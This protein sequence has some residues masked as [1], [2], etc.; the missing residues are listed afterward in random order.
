LLAVLVM[1]AGVSA[2][3]SPGQLL[4]SL[5]SGLASLE[6]TQ[7]SQV[8]T[9]Q[10]KYWARDWNGNIWLWLSCPTSG[11]TIR[12]TLDGSTP[13]FYSPVC[14]VPLILSGRGT[15]KV[16]AFKDGMLASKILVIYIH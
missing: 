11:A 5:A 16:R 14:K 13:Q 12:R 9:P 8:Q 15:L 4:P 6:V 3:P 7:M 1:S 2:A 10:L